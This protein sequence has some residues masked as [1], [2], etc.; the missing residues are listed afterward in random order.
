MRIIAYATV[1]FV[2]VLLCTPVR[3]DEPANGQTAGPIPV[4]EVNLIDFD[5]SA[6]D[7]YARLH[8]QLPAAMLEANDSPLHDVR[9]VD[10]QT[11]DSPILKISANVPFSYYDD[12]IAARYQV[13][14]QGTQFMYPFDAHNTSL[15]FFV[16][17]DMGHGKFERLPIKYDCSQCT[18]DGFDVSIHDDGT[19]PTD[20]RLRVNITRTKPII[21]FSLA[22]ALAMWAMT[23]VVVLM[24]YRVIRL[25]KEVPDVATMGFIGGLLF[26]FPAIRST[27]PRVPPMG[28]L[29]D[30]Y[31]FF[32]CEFILIVALVVVTIAWIRF[33]GTKGS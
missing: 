17:Q 31:G 27:Q 1:L 22:I 32:W 24:A 30:Y 12:F 5:P 9:L 25:N 7:V 10:S 3:A 14:D 23:I 21:I 28:V 8:L 2:G 20:V 13:N 29:S 6:G 11:V 16:S 19:T 15:G 18:V 4:V 33:P 26:A